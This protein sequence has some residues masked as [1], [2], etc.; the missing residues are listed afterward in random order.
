MCGVP[1][2]SQVGQDWIVSRSLEILELMH[3]MLGGLRKMKDIFWG[4]GDQDRRSSGAALVQCSLSIVAGYLFF[5]FA[6]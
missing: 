5:L 3:G 2:Q 6:Q 1:E 4:G